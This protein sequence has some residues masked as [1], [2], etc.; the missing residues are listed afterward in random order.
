MSTSKKKI[1]EGYME[2]HQGK[3]VPEELIKPIDKSRDELV[4]EIV[5]KAKALNEA[6]AVFKGGVME[7]VEA[8]IAES[9]KKYNVK[10]GGN[11]G[12][13]TLYSFDGQYKVQ[14]AIA[15]HL[16][17][18]ERLQVAKELIDKCIHEWTEGSRSEI[19]ALINDAFQ[20]DKEGRV[21]TA[22]ILGLQRLDI[23]DRNWKKAMQAIRDSM[24]VAGSKAY[25]RVYERVGMSDQYKPIPL[26]VAG[27]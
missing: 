12:N 2:D 21:S 6:L 1:P 8:F 15:E 22:R 17:F 20:V 3:L 7:D 14:R 4:R 19:K 10:M 5:A 24:Q 11:K 25:V 13:V 9:G 18:D 23:T 16:V 27:V 26:D